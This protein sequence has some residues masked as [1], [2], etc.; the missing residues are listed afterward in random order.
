[1]SERRGRIKNRLISPFLDQCQTAQ[2]NQDSCKQV[3]HEPV[4][5][6]L[7]WRWQL[8]GRALPPCRGR[9]SFPSAQAQWDTSGAVWFWTPSM[10]HGESPAKDH[11]DS[12]G[13]GASIKQG[14]VRAETA[15]P[16]EEKAQGDFPNA[17]KYL[18]WGQCGK[19]IQTLL[20]GIKWQNKRARGHKLKCE[21]SF[22]HKEN[23]F[24][25]EGDWTRSRLHR[26]FV[27][28]SSLR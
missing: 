26:D 11:Q 24:Y 15:Q 22:K 12:S 5:C 14:D 17:Y 20:S 10:G 13:L 18:V 21:I 9:W 23:L 3:E 8:L 19:W 25:C 27:D 7:Y 16:V 6:P 2:V 28:S 1:M 4:V